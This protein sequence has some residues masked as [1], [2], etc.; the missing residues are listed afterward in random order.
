MNTP[1]EFEIPLVET[2][3]NTSGRGNGN[4]LERMTEVPEGASDGPT[5]EGVYMLGDS[6]AL[7]AQRG[8]SASTC[9]DQPTGLATSSITN[10]SATLS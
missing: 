1:S 3:Q 7:Y 10:K 4:T 8:Q 9:T 5:R 2:P 6:I